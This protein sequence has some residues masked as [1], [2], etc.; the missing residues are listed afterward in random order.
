MEISQATNY[1]KSQSIFAL[2]PSLQVLKELVEMT[3]MSLQITRIILR[4]MN[5][6]VADLV[7]TAQEFKKA[8]GDVCAV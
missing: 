3:D 6:T 4:Y 8:A 7:L 2:L 5:Y 1:P